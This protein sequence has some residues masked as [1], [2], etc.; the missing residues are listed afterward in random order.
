M[1]WSV[2]RWRAGWTKV[3]T[4]ERE[5]DPTGRKSGA[6][7]RLWSQGGVIEEGG[8]DRSEIVIRS[9]VRGLPK[10]IRR[11]DRWQ[12]GRWDPGQCDGSAKERYDE[13]SLSTYFIFGRR[14]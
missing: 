13:F 9:R 7:S 14:L 12:R 5:Q 1:R 6:K 10:S 11:P 3:I 2:M 8:V 4:V